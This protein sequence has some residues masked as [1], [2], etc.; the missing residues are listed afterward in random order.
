MNIWQTI[1]LAIAGIRANKLRSF[2]TMLG[3]II[4][5]AA[6]IVLVSI[7][8]GAGKSVTGQIQ[9]LGSNLVSITIRT[10]ETPVTLG[11]EEIM[12]WKTRIGI[13]GV[14]PVN[15]GNVTVKYGN[16][17]YDTSLEGVN[18]EYEQ[19]RNFHVQKGRFIIHSDLVYRQKV[20]LLG[21]DVAGQLFG[22]LD[23][24]GETVRI[25]GQNFLVVG[26]LESKGGAAFGSNDDKVIIPLTTAERLLD[27][28]GI[29]SV[30]VQA[31]G[32][33]VV[34]SVVA[35]L[36]NILFKRIKNTD[37]YRVNN[38][39]DMLATVSQV[40]GTLTLMLGGIA[41]I[42]LLVGGIGIMNIMLVSVTERTREIGIRKA[43][44]GKRG[45]ILRQFLIEAL[46]VSC[47]GG[48]LG[49]LIGLGGASVLGKVMAME[50]SVSLRIIGMAFGFSLLVGVL[51]G[52][53]P[54][55]KAAKLNPIEAL[56]YQ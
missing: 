21:T 11:Y 29:R 44:G 8:E 46:V 13:Q 10:N 15:N 41:G 30:Y 23:S 3:V 22:Q 20:V 50:T 4:G 12:E 33:E 14:A 37:A 55:N 49:I 54:A 16:K 53:Y 36:D 52:L 34:D 43:I 25:N 32:P 38:Q 35:Q 17:K 42:S 19:V 2:L 5:V 56:R 26:L 6:V 39:A 45:D 47:S 27:N 7:G 18:E 28:K 9:G 24:I 31:A 40:T 48:V 51:F 1:K